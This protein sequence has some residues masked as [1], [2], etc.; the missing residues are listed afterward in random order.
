MPDPRTED[1][2]PSANVKDGKGAGDNDLKYRWELPIIWAV[3]LESMTYLVDDVRRHLVL[4][5][6]TVDATG[7]EEED[8]CN[9][10]W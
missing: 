7:V 4:P 2:E 8:A 1:V 5:G 10:S 9:E 6:A 3:A